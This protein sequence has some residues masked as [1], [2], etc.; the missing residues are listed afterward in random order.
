MTR[1][2]LVRH[3]ESEWNADGRWQ[4]QADP[5]L[6]ERGRRQAV[7]AASA[8]GTIDAIVTSDLER[9]AETGAILARLL[10]VDH[11]ATEPRLRERDAGSL[12][13]LTRVEIHERFPGLLPD[14]PAGFEPDEHGQPRWPHD[15]EHDD[16]LWERVEVA[17]LALGRLVPDGDV[18]AV[19]HGGV[20]YATERRLGGPDRGRLSNLE[21][22]WLRVE[23]DRFHLGDRVL[24]VDPAETL[25]IEADRI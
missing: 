9:A 17:L 3:G 25:A 15:W 12:S 5:P 2:L 23:D 1:I 6:T 18:V 22:C 21:G 20:M 10:G 14:D 11:L 24:L 16:P 4:G 19:T 7:H 13:G 8:L